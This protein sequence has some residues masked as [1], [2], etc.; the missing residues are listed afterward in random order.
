MSLG[1]RHLDDAKMLIK[2]RRIDG[3][4]ILAVFGLEE[5][6]RIIILKDKYK[7]AIAKGVNY[8]EIKD[9]K[10]P[11]RKD[12]F[13]DHIK[14]QRKA[15]QILPPGSLRL[16]EG[17]FGEGFGK[18]FDID[19]YLNQELREV[20]SYLDF[21]HMWQTSRPIDVDSLKNCINEI[22]KAIKAQAII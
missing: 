9:R 2:K 3:A 7:K 4:T 12:P 20:S 14:K 22:E 17:G 10:Q 18:G 8:I 5:L 11:G 15:T 19:I 16:H 13:Y 21:C 6:G 1:L